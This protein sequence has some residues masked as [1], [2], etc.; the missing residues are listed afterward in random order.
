M[1][2][3]VRSEKVPEPLI[4][5]EDIPVLKL[6]TVW[7]ADKTV[8]GEEFI[9]S[10]FL[11]MQYHLDRTYHANLLIYPCVSYTYVS[12]WGDY[13]VADGLHTFGDMDAFNHCMVDWSER[14]EKMK[15]FHAVI[16]KG[17]EYLVG[18]FEG[19]DNCYVSSALRVTGLVDTEV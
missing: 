15:L 18:N 11:L 3:Y 9:E 16:P 12:R 10:P 19:T 2:L 1:C 4:A 14:D 13:T 6:L 7:P 5:E 17:S 8:T